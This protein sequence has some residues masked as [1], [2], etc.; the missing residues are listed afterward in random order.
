MPNGTTGSAGASGQ[1]RT[2]VRLNDVATVEL[3]AESYTTS[4]TY[5][6]KNA[7]GLAISLA[8]GANAISTAQAV[9]AT[10]S[11]LSSTFPQGVEVF[12]PYDTAPFVRLSIEDVV[13]TLIEAI[14]LVFIVKF[15]FLQDIRATIIPTLAVPV[16]LLGTFGVLA[17]FGYSINT[18][19][20][21]A[22]VL[23]IG[24]RFDQLPRSAGCGALVLYGGRQPDRQ[25][26]RHC[27][28][29]HCPRQSARRWM[30]WC[31]R[32][33]T[34]LYHRRQYR[35]APRN[36]RKRK[37]HWGRHRAVRKQFDDWQ[38]LA[39]SGRCNEAKPAAPKRRPR[40]AS[41][42]DA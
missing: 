37:S 40:S 31:Y 1:H 9:Q 30:G 32:Q 4:A 18:L 38:L 3:G 26:R 34:T 39:Q 2:V 8:T 29:L 25:P 6:G 10:I 14:V 20:M 42:S 17:I 5:N 28:I 7:A 16:V 13:K 12:Y 23:A 11:R 24:V 19:T 36:W 22:V 33:L 21:F 27:N 41:A 35:S 15:V